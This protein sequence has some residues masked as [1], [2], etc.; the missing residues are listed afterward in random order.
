MEDSV[1]CGFLHL[2]SA[3]TVPELQ[4]VFTVQDSLHPTV[5]VGVAVGVFVTV[6]VGVAVGVSVIVTVMLGVWVGVVVSVGVCV[7]VCVTVF[8]DIGTVGVG[9]SSLG[10][11]SVGFG[12]F[13]SLQQPSTLSQHLYP[14]TQHVK[15]FPVMFVQK[16]RP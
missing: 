9:V 1:H 10:G 5:E 6:L 12:G 16:A 11:L 8:V 4:S 14:A 13:P 3:Q 7:G 2:P 15:P